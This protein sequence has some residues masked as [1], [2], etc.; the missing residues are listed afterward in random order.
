MLEWVEQLAA[1]LERRA[2]L[3]HAKAAEERECCYAA[4]IRDEALRSAAELRAR[5]KG[6]E[7]G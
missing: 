7:R 3:W 1:E 5:A 2:M 6:G 4:G